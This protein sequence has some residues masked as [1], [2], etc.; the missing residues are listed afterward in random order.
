MFFQAVIIVKVNNVKLSPG[1][2]LFVIAVMAIVM[3]AVVEASVMLHGTENLYLFS[4]VCAL[5]IV[6]ALKISDYLTE[7]LV[8]K[9]DNGKHHG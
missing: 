7:R 3:F 2:L 6:L 9:E 8:V 1:A 5:M 4:G